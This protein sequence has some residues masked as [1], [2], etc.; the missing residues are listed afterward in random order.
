MDGFNLGEIPKIVY[1]L[2]VTYIIWTHLY[3][4]FS[5]LHIVWQSLY[6]IHI[7]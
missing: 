2:D 4:V 1:R 5:I 7:I 3:N 6:N